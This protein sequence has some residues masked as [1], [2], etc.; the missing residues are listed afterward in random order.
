MGAID[1]LYTSTVVVTTKVGDKLNGISVAWVTRVSW[2]PVMLAISIGKA[3]YSHE[4]LLNADGFCVCVLGKSAEKVAEHFGTLS[5]RDV[6][7][8]A[9][10][11][12]SFSKRGYP[13]P[14]GTIA[15]MECEKTSSFEAGDH[16]IFVGK[17]ID[18]KILKDEE[19]MIFGEGKILP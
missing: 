14:E 8:F 7:K 17:V 19:P 9:T 2:H 16:T 18:G 15:Y 12:H 1:K 3:R 11:P 13:V 6:N 4:L 10:V 5:G